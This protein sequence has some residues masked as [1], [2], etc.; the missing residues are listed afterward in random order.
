MEMTKYIPNAMKNSVYTK[1]TALFSKEEMEKVYRFHRSMG[2]KYNQTP[3]ARL[4]ALAASLGLGGLYVKDESRRG[5]LKAFKLLGGAYAV[6]SS[7]CRKLG[8]S[9]TDVDFAYLKSDEVKRKLGDLTFAAAS[10]GNHGKSVAWAA[11]EF[12]Q[13]S[14]VYMPKGTVR[15][16]I[17]AIER[18][19]GTV[20]VSDDNYDWCVREVNRLAAEKGWEVV[21]DT[22]SEGDA[23]V[24]TWVMQ[25]YATMAIEA[26]EQLGDVVPTHMFLQ[27]GVG[28]MAAAMAGVFINHYGD[29]CPKIYIMEP[30][31]AACYYDSG[32][33]NDGAARSVDGDMDS[34]MAGLSCGV[35]N[36]ISWEIIRNFADGFFSCSDVLTANGMRILGNPLADDPRVVAG[37]S[38]AVGTGL[39]DEIMKRRPDIAAEIGLNTSSRVIMFSTEGD[40]DTQNYRNIVWY[41]KYPRV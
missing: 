19:G 6:A 27:A 37:E 24:A 17:E 15:D 21:L 39:V 5:N 35:P 40:T 2:D 22:A 33:A 12:N 25:G 1:E 10:D 31:Q 13:R 16:R 4:D 20:V 36:P 32:A 11:H 30:H 29:K 3:L 23:Q 7:I 34:I 38:G 26:I 28:S 41:G 18:F 8:V 14:I 9:I